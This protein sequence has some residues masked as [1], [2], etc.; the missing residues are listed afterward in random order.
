L[1]ICFDI[2]PLLDNINHEIGIEISQSK[3]IIH[4]LILKSFIKLDCIEL[5]DK[6]SNS[7]VVI[8]WNVFDLQ[9]PCTFLNR[10]MGFVDSTFGHLMLLP[11]E[12]NV[13]AFECLVPFNQ[14]VDCDEKK[15]VKISK[16]N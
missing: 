16:T 8:H 10:Y 6:I 2:N 5:Q 13:K 7:L 14:G 3:V 12:K 1:N 4:T 9:F 11:T 15:H